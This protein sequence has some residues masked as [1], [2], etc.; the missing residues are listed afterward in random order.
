MR[1]WIRLIVTLMVFFFCSQAFTASPKQAVQPN[2]ARFYGGFGFG[3]TEGAFRGHEASTTAASFA[4]SIAF[5]STA[6]LTN[7]SFIRSLQIGY[8]WEWYRWYLGLYAQGDYYDLSRMGRLSSISS[9]DGTGV[10]YTPVVRL[11]DSASFGIKAGLLLSPATLF[12]LQIAANYARA[13]VDILFQSDVLDFETQASQNSRKDM[14]S[15]RFGLGIE[16]KITRA[17]S[18][19]LNYMYTYYSHVTAIS[20]NDNTVQ[21]TRVRFSNSTFLAGI[22]YYFNSPAITKLHNLANLLNGFY[23]GIFGGYQQISTRQSLDSTY[24]NPRILDITIFNLKNESLFGGVTLGYNIG[25]RIFQLGFSADSALGIGYTTRIQFQSLLL[26]TSQT[27]INSTLT[28][29][30]YAALNINP[31]LLLSAKTFLFARFGAVFSEFRLSTHKLLNLPDVTY[32]DNSY[33]SSPGRIGCRFGLGIEHKFGSW[34][35]LY[36]LEQ[37]TLYP[38][39]TLT[40]SSTTSVIAVTHENIVIK[41]KPHNNQILLGLNFY[42]TT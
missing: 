25:W 19:W 18:L 41:I 29:R 23:A 14:I 4:A 42:L 2:F 12:Y 40:Q 17:L 3:L 11:S 39:I 15:P 35:S 31:G 36:L 26:A 7:T 8:G 13:H 1:Q 6:F 16:Q 38:S 10:V 32:A 24:L 5:Q 21:N 33:S 20:I 22:N 27:N 28:E 30:D 37:Y 9:V 34:I